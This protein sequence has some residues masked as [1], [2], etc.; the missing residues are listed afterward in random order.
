LPYTADWTSASSATQLGQVMDGQWTFDGRG[1]RPVSTGF[2]RL[3]TL[4]DTRWANYEV[5]ARITFNSL[6][7]SRP[8]VGSAAGLAVGWQGHTA[9]GQPRFGHPSAGLCLYAWDA[10]NPLF[11]KVQLG[12]SPGEAN[13]TVV[14]T[15][16]MDLALG[17]EHIMRFRHVD[18]GNG[19]ARYSCKVWPAD[20]PEPS[21]WTVQAD[22][23]YWPSETATHPGSVVLVAH[24]AD[25]TFGAVTVTPVGG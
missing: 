6:D 5:T 2:D 10:A 7:T 17:R 9:W 23:P 19:A 18:L 20:N 14:A 11:Y 4:G 3:V 1:I 21:A 25:A 8:S 13:D 15:N 16:V 24:M 22:I 12:Y